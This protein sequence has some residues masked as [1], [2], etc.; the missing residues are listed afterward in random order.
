[1]SHKLL[2]FFFVCCAPKHGKEE[3]MTSV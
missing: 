3:Y 1:M 2:I